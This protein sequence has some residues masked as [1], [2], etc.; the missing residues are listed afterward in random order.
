MDE[1]PTKERLGGPKAQSPIKHCRSGVCSYCP[2][3]R[4]RIP[5]LISLSFEILIDELRV[6]QNRCRPPCIATYFRD[7]LQLV[8]FASLNN[9]LSLSDFLSPSASSK[10]V[11]A[12]AE[13]KQA[14]KVIQFSMN[15]LDQ[16]SKKVSQ[17][18]GPCL[19][20][21]PHCKFYLSL[22]RTT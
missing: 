18:H 22:S 21:A 15:E 2:E 12:V 16:C 9:N 19:T 1:S 3:F 13:K 6:K 11:L 4:Y 5:Y 20:P 17:S 7:P 8:V 10:H 14:G